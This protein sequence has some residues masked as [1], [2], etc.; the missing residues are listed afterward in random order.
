MTFFFRNT[1]A[2]G[3][4]A[5][6]LC[7][8]FVFDVIAASA[9]TTSIPLPEREVSCDTVSVER[10]TRDT[11]RIVETAPSRRLFPTFALKTNLLPW[12]AGGANLKAEFRLGG[13]LSLAAGGAFSNWR[14]EA[15]RAFQG[16]RG[17]LDLKYWFNNEGRPFTGW[18]CG[19]WG[20]LGGRF[21]V[22]RN[23]G[24]QGDRFYSS[25]VVGGYSFAVGRT[26]NVEVS[27]SPG[28]F[29]TP[30]MRHYHTVDNVLVWQQTSYD[31]KRVMFKCS[32][33]LVWFP[34]KKK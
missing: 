18:H 22:Q 33:D 13:H 8:G 27:A 5:A 12:A 4:L 28:L 17:G 31:A 14:N 20:V 21:D 30:E 26:L 32:V 3:R 2:T 16:A 1:I 29:Y 25:G 15:R 6:L 10:T 19:V 23:S 7:A 11:V 24:W 9:K 34:G